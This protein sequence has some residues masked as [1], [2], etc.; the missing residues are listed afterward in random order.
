VY[1][2]DN[3]R[4]RF[5]IAPSFSG[6][7][8]HWEQNGLNHLLSP[9][10]EPKT[11]GWMSPWYGGITPV[12]MRESGWDLPG[13]LYQET[14]KATIVKEPDARG[15]L[16]RG[17]RVSAEIA[18]EQLLGLG[19]EF[20]YL[21]V[22]DSNVLKLVCRVHNRTTAKRRLEV[23]WLTY[24]QLDGAS[25]GN[26]LRSQDI[27]RKHTPW[28]SWPEAGHWGALT[29][30]GTERTAMLISPHPDVK[31]IDWGDVGGHLG[32]S[33]SID[34]MPLSTSKTQ[35]AK[36]TCYVALCESWN[37]AQAYTC[38]SKYI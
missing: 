12:V 30:P 36:R 29:H 28:E 20:D 38:L 24:W 3:G 23:G 13:K 10:P 7:L 27:E 2:I 21:T 14:L 9:F 25:T 17:L 5:R 37:Q 32:C 4:S 8:T 19:V 15:I 34:V 31:L 16:W 33:R 11:F 26:T 22:G 1:E 35:P 6:A 18:R